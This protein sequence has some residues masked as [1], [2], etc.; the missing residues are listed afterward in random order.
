MS[1]TMNVHKLKGESD[2]TLFE[3]ILFVAGTIGAIICGRKKKYP[4]MF[5][6]IVISAAPFILLVL[7]MIL[8]TGID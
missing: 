8:I 4:A 6:C 7:T 1:F 2:M 3:V 5:A